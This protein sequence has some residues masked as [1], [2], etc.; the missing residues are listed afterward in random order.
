[1]RY[2]M[3]L[4]DAPGDLLRYTNITRT[5]LQPYVNK[6]VTELRLNFAGAAYL[7]GSANETTKLH[8]TIDEMVA[9]GADVCLAIQE[10]ESVLSVDQYLNPTISELSVQDIIAIQCKLLAHNP[11]IW[12]DLN[13]PNHWG[14]QV[15]QTYIDNMIAIGLAVRAQ[16]PNAKMYLPCPGYSGSTQELT[17][18]WSNST[19]YG[20]INAQ[21]HFNRVGL[22]WY[23]GISNMAS[24]AQTIPGIDLVFQEYHPG[25]VLNGDTDLGWNK[26]N[27]NQSQVNAYMDA[28]AACNPL[29]ACGWAYADQDEQVPLGLLTLNAMGQM[30]DNWFQTHSTN[31]LSSISLPYLN[32]LLYAN[33]STSAIRMGQ[34]YMAYVPPTSITLNIT[35]L[36]EAQ[37]RCQYWTVTGEGGTGIYGHYGDFNAN[38][39]D[40]DFHFEGSTDNATWSDVPQATVPTG[41]SIRGAVVVGSNDRMTHHALDVRGFNYVRVTFTGG[42]GFQ[43]G[44]VAADF[45]IYDASSLHTLSDWYS[46]DGFVDIGDSITMLAALYF[47]GMTSLLSTSS[48]TA[49]VWD[50]CGSSGIHAYDWVNDTEFDRKISQPG[51]FVVLSLGSNDLSNAGVGS[52]NT[53][54]ATLETMVAKIKAKGK[55]ALINSL[56]Y[57]NG[58]T[59]AD[60][61]A[62]SQVRQAL[63]DTTVLGTQLANYLRLHY[64]GNGAYFLTDLT[65]LFRAH[66]EL[67]RPSDLH[68]NDFTL[69]HNQMAMD[70]ISLLFSGVA[71]NPSTPAPTQT[72]LPFNRNLFLLQIK[73]VTP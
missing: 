49:P 40:T 70:V 18:N 50:W 2:G 71:A 7:R 60:G 9:T 13:E 41:L 39:Y 34:D 58:P 5:V 62:P 6:G 63:D 54:L 38:R 65:A 26:D 22:H 16:Y 69:Y 30:I 33:N 48:H 53:F 64:N 66:P 15:N 47:L 68:P 25:Q 51:K 23:G 10:I 19:V 17:R 37:K 1:M 46:I 3:N 29:L 73:G 59:V 11:N 36:T 32:P 8:A 44:Q 72:T 55:I 52:I 21:V 61:G 56:P 14:Q 45:N 31:P 4:G 67:M 42:E 35:A 12:V 27:A 28:I 43:N 57:P 24:N 20:L